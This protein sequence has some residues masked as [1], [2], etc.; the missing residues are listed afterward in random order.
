M[1]PN[2]SC[3]SPFPISMPI[4]EPR[5]IPRRI[6]NITLRKSR[7]EYFEN[8]REENTRIRFYKIG[9][10]F[11]LGALL[12]GV[13]VGMQFGLPWAQKTSYPIQIANF[14]FACIVYGLVHI[15]QTPLMQETFDTNDYIPDA[16]ADKVV[17]LHYLQEGQYEGHLKI[18]LESSSYHHI[19]LTKEDFIHLQK[20]GATDIENADELNLFFQRRSIKNL[21]SDEI[22][23]RDT[24][25]SYQKFLHLKR[26]TSHDI[27]LQVALS[28]FN[29]YHKLLNDKHV[30]FY[31][32][33]FLDPYAE[34]RN[35][36]K[37]IGYFAFI[38]EYFIANTK[39]NKDAV[40]AKMGEPDKAHLRNARKIYSKS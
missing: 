19:Q 27:L 2:L 5:Q 13:A 29:E 7:P 35:E 33:I 18:L 15:F 4:T 36:I 32:N 37:K 17:R 39:K 11:F 8:L 24:E 12:G 14:G 31:A 38:Y 20:I 30:R 16:M 3:V 21:E 10:S 22:T 6:P 40:F 23:T 25:K 34:S 28:S 1:T 9:V 26:L